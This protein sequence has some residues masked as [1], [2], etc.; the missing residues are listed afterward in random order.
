MYTLKDQCRVESMPALKPRDS[1]CFRVRGSLVKSV[2]QWGKGSFRL[3]S[4]TRVSSRWGTT[5]VNP[6]Q[7]GFASRATVRVDLSPLIVS[8]Q[9]GCLPQGSSTARGVS[10]GRAI[11]QA[12][13]RHFRS[14]RRR[15]PPSQ[16]WEH[17]QRA[18]HWGSSAKIYQPGRLGAR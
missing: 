17:L 1:S 16:S 11:L 3:A 5:G 13:S 18:M 8:L 10:C 9:T 14:A 15:F 12:P 6:M 7:Q 4:R 2:P